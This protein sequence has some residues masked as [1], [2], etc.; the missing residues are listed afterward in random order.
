MRVAFMGTPAFA[1]P[2]LEGLVKSD[3]RVVAVV[4]QPS[5]RAGR[6]RR[7]RPPPTVR[8]AQ[9]H[10]IEVLQPRAIK[11]GPFPERWEALDADVAVVV[12]YGRIL[13]PRLLAAPRHGCVNVHASL[14]PRYR[15]A[16]PVQWAV[17][18]GE[19]VTGSTTML[20]DDG[21]DTGPVLLQRKLS[22]GPQETAADLL[23]RLAH[24]GAHLLLETLDRFH[25]IEPTPQDHA[26]HTLAPPL[27]KE[28]GRVDWSR[29]ASEIHDRVRG[30]TPWPGAWA[31]FRGDR[32]RLHR[33]QP[34]EWEACDVE[35]GAVVEARK[36]LIVAAGT[37]AVEILEAQLPCKR[38]QPGSALV[39]GARIAVGEVFE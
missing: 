29:S 24:Q 38:R 6:G 1:V 9:E 36:S 12:A 39:C 3:H 14:L 28:D 8:L 32:L 21:L 34:L 5:R 33:V 30:M 18:R 27:S 23:D 25:E 26:R 10:D 17:T 4:A 19:R 16:A 7:L 35:P 2:T 22:I 31:R 20:M 37:D 13:T 15:G 11:R